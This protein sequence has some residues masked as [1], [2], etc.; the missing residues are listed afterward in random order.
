MN[1]STDMTQPQGTHVCPLPY[2]PRALTRAEKKRKD[3]YAFLSPKLDR[4]V[5]VLGALGF[6]AALTFEFDPTVV[7]YCE[8][9]RT[10]R[11]DR[12][13]VEMAYWTRHANDEEHLWVLVPTKESDAAAGGRRRF[14]HEEQL[15]RV[16]QTL[17][18]SVRFLYEQDFIKQRTAI[19]IWL[20]LLP[21]VQTARVLE[22]RA[23]VEARVREYF[24][25]ATAA[26]FERL[27]KSLTGYHPHD[28][29]AIA[30][31]GIHSDWLSIDL[32]RPLHVRTVVRRGGHYGQA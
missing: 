15:L 31:A 10:L 6:A 7:S 12:R 21:Y 29:R 28:V 5:W 2:S 1:L 23:A 22:N 4:E 16:A 9:P 11:V 3:V 20:A 18:I 17:Q 30:C 13:T 25:F 14:R 27:E 26:T 19:G 32:S 8:R 24:Q